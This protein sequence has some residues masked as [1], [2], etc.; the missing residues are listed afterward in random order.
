M[1]GMSDPEREP[2]LQ[3][4]TLFSYTSSNDCISPNI[5]LG[6]QPQDARLWGRG[7]I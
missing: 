6:V 1:D 2:M 7:G 5:V 3:D 4:F